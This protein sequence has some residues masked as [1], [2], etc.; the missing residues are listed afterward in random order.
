MERG[1]LIANV[2]ILIIVGFLL[3][4]VLFYAI[5]KFLERREPYASFMKLHTR[6]KIRFFRLLAA[7]PG[8]PKRVKALPIFLAGYLAF[9]FDIIPDFIPVLGYVDDIAIVVATLALIVRWTPRELI[10]ELIVRAGE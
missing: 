4:V 9:P 6:Q 1:L 5:S 3:L 8:L 10:D 2:V 7:S